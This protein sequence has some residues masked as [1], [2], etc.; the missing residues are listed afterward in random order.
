[1]QY[2]FLLLFVPMFPGNAQNVPTSLK[3]ISPISNFS[4]EWDAPKYQACNTAA[5]ANYMNEQEKNVIWIL[6]L[7]RINPKLFCQTVV[8]KYPEYSINDELEAT[9]Y[10]KSLVATLNSM[11]PLGLLQPDQQCYTSAQCHA[12]N[13]GVSGTEG[14]ERKGSCLAKEYYNGECCDYSNAD[15]I[16][17]VM[18][19]LI[20]E[21]VPSLGHRS[22]CLSSEYK[23]LGVSIQPHKKWVTNAVLDFH[24]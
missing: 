19:L 6:N 1:M 23:I 20:D 4:E 3:T 7:A 17:I 10:Y 8:K 14:H 12:Y 15:A 11:K 24:L 16:D 22:I 9:T 5:T 13:S 21:D 18:S 2:L